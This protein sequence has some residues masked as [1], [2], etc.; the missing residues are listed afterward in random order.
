VIVHSGHTA[1]ERRR[2][3]RAMRGAGAVSSERARS[4]EQLGLHDSPVFRSYRD[5]NIVREGKSGGFYLD[6]EA[7]REFQRM[8]LR[9]LLVPVLAILALVVYAIIR[10]SR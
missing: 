10:S 8:L 5:R 4:L 2:V 1:H 7:L 9:W 6:E 3:I